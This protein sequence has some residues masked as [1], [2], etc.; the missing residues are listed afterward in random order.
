MLPLNTLLNTLTWFKKAVPE[1]SKQ[2]IQVQLG[3][4]FEEVVEML[5]EI[6]TNDETTLVHLLKARQAMSDLAML[7]KK[8]NA[9]IS[10]PNRVA[11]LDAICDQLVTATGSA[12]MM[13][14]DPIAGLDEVNRSNWSKFVDGEPVFN[15]D[16]KITKGPEYTKPI[17]DPFV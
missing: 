10:V 7:L 6:H 8:N 1:P 15:S 2:N 12:Y 5:Y 14:M 13:G 3:V 9:T 17:L 4:H 16:M 11:M